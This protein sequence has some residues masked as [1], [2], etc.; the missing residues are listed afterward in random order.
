MPDISKIYNEQALQKAIVE[1]AQASTDLLTIERR[2]YARAYPL[3]VNRGAVAGDGNRRDTRLERL[4]KIWQ[5]KSWTW[6]L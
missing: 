1:V 4:V 6:F 2:I 3:G 5:V